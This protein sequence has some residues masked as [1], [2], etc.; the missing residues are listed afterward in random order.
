MSYVAIMKH[1]SYER[2]RRNTYDMPK[3]L[4]KSGH[5]TEIEGNNAGA[6]KMGQIVSFMKHM[7]L[8]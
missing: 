3:G 6:F 8:L 7:F 1:S 2:G 5:D 4:F